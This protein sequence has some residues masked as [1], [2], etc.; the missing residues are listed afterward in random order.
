[1]IWTFG[2]ARSPGR[3]NMLFVAATFLAGLVHRSVYV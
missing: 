1:M 3:G 2:G